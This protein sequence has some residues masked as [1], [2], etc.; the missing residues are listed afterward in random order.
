[1][2]HSS[3]PSLSLDQVIPPRHCCR[4]IMQGVAVRCSFERAV[5]TFCRPSGFSP[6]SA[7]RF[8]IDC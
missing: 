5:R 2:V 6:P 1:M 7:R 4:S 3:H 8:R